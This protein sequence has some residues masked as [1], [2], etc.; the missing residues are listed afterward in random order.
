MGQRTGP[1]EGV[2]TA[3]LDH[4][5]SGLEPGPLGHSMLTMLSTNLRLAD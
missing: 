4:C 3:N 5:K 2:K 1:S